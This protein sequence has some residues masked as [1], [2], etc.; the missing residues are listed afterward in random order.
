[1]WKLCFLLLFPKSGECGFAVQ[2]KNDISVHLDNS[3]N[4]IQPSNVLDKET[5]VQ[6][7]EAPCLWPYGKVA[8]TLEDFLGLLTPRLVPLC[9]H[10]V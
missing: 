10:Q 2:D 6:R 8:M 7:S 9:P 4:Q 1:M 3:K 5:E